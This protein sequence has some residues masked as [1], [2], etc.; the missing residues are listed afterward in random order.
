M[1]LSWALPPDGWILEE[2]T[3]L[4]GSPTAWEPTTAGYQTNAVQIRVTVSSP[5]GSRFYRLRKP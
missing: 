2:A 1:T 4:V 3:A 5:S